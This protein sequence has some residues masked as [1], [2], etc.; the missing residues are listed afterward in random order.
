M[1]SLAG[2][3]G[4][5]CANIG[6]PGDVRV[7]LAG[8]AA[9][10]GARDASQ[11]RKEQRDAASDAHEARVALLTPRGEIFAPTGARS[12]SSSL[13]AVRVQEWDGGASLAF[14][15]AARFSGGS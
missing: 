12:S 6:H 13:V 10:G 2:A 15:Y 3:D 8:Y 9:L 4:K 7:L 14:S 11:E 1:V 5:I